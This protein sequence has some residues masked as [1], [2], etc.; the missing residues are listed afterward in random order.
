MT[1]TKVLKR[2]REDIFGA[3]ENGVGGE[4]LQKTLFRFC[5]HS[6]IKAFFMALTVYKGLSQVSDFVLLFN[7]H[8][9]CI[10]GRT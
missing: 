8:L 3:D 2:Y 1:D 7:M 10:M 4:K 6:L 5:R 9:M